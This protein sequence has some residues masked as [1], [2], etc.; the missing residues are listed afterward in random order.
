LSVVDRTWVFL[1]FCLFPPSIPPKGGEAEP[2][3]QGRGIPILPPLGGAEPFPQGKGI[4]VLP[5]LGGVRGGGCLSQLPLERAVQ[6]RRQQGVQLRLGG[7]L[8]G[9][10]FVHLGLQVVQVGNYVILL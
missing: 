8:E 10:E 1:S 6:Y 4:L 5:P 2:F 7:V 3:L 9:G